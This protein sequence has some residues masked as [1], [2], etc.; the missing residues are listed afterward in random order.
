MTIP[1]DGPALDRLWAGWRRAFV[2]SVGDG[3]GPA[4][5]CVFCAIL[6]SGLPDDETHLLWRHPRG[7][8]I[9]ILNLYPYTSGHLMV[10]PTRH[11]GEVE[12]VTGE[13][14]AALW[15]GVSA[16][17]GALKAAYRP[18]ALNLGAN[19]GR[20][21]GAGVPGH[22]HVHVVPRWNGDTNFMTTVADARVLPEA[23]TDTGARL[24]AAWP[25]PP[26]VS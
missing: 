21:A 14:S 24:R 5:E 3:V 15:T 26:E 6:A 20:A 7:L 1:S 18:D 13:E 11:V 16:A 4:P 17:V 25:V 8:A 19:V 12:E 2:T 23:L 10:M 22:F 9:A